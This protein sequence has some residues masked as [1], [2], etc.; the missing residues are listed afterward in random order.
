[1]GVRLKEPTR[2]THKL[3]VTEAIA[4]LSLKEQREV[5]VFPEFMVA[6]P[7]PGAGPEELSNHQ[8]HRQGN[9]A[10]IP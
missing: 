7:V 6:G 5:T 8:N 4:S 2:G 1:M 3:T 10:N 9:W